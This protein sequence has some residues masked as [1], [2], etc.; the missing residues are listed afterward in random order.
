MNTYE[1]TGLTNLTFNKA[2]NKTSSVDTEQ[3]N[4]INNLF[5]VSAEMKMNY[6]KATEKYI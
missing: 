1:Y 2:F 3:F 5:V 4:H 6:W